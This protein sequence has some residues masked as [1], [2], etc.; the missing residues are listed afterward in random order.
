M[1]TIRVPRSLA[2]DR[3]LP[4][5]SVHSGRPAEGFAEAGRAPYVIRVP[6]TQAE[7][8]QVQML[9]KRQTSALYGGVLCVAFGIAMARF[10]VLLPLGLVIGLVSAGLWG[11]GWFLLRRLLPQVEPGPGADEFTLRGVHREFAAAMLLE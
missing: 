9:K 11:A 6:L 5:I 10:P 8:D 2:R 7:F 3:G 1:A 4:P